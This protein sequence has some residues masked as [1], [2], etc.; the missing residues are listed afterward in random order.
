MICLLSVLCVLYVLCA[1][2][3]LCY[4]WYVCYVCVI[5]SMCIVLAMCVC[6]VLHVHGVVDGVNTYMNREKNYPLYM[7]EPITAELNWVLS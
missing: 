2:C 3:A 7:Y 5:C 1:L 4:S 6:W